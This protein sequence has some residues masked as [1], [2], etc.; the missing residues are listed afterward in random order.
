MKHVDKLV[1]M[2]NQIS[3][4]LAVN[5]EARAVTETADHISRFWEPRMR[6]LIGEHLSEGGEG[7]SPLSVKALN[8]L[9]ESGRL[10]QSA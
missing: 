3:K 2:A 10:R 7:L 4:H 6:V 9:A 8:V 1:M 5:G